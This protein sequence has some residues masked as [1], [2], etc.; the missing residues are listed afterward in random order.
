MKFPDPNI[1]YVFGYKSRITSQGILVTFL[2]GKVKILFK[3]SDIVRV[4]REVYSGGRI[5]WD[6]IRW[7]KCPSGTDAVKIVLKHGMYRNHFIVFDNMAKA[8]S[9]LKNDGIDIG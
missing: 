9:D 1:G 4:H 3:Y 8:I 7:G 2:G 6:V 5:S